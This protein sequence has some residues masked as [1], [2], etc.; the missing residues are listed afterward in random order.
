MILKSQTYSDN[1]DIS[2]L[3]FFYVQWSERDPAVFSLSPFNFKLHWSFWEI[4][5]CKLHSI[6]YNFVIFIWYPAGKAW[7]PCAPAVWATLRDQTL[8]WRQRS[9][10]RRI[11]P[12][13]PL[14]SLLNWVGPARFLIP[15]KQRYVHGFKK[16][17]PWKGYWPMLLEM[18][19]MWKRGI[20]KGEYVKEKRRKW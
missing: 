12:F 5:S 18:R 7:R 4:S 15:W 1:V 13:T 10:P 14:S 8:R 3:M 11:Q 2:M 19:G 6:L 9:P 17:W 20:E 16:M